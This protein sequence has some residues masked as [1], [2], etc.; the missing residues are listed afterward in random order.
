MKPSDF[1]AYSLVWGLAAVLMCGAMYCGFTGVNPARRLHWY[2][3]VSLVA[4]AIGGCF[5][6]YLFLFGDS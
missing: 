1:L 4:V 2:H 5:A 3:R 6:V